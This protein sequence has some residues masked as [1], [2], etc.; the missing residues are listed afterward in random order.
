[1]EHYKILCTGN[2]DDFT[3]AHFVKEAFP[4]TVFVSRSNGYNLDVTDNKNEQ[5]FRNKIK[6]F[7][8]FINSSWIDGNQIN[9]LEI[10]QQEWLNKKDCYVIN[11][12]SNAEFDGDNF[13]DKN[14]SRKKLELRELSLASNTKDFRTTHIILGGLQSTTET[15]D[16]NKIKLNDVVETVKWILNCNVRIPLI[17]IEA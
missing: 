4:D 9:L 8:V 15:V 5:L 13:F 6:D 10:V 2:P 7:N 16:D 12:G 11:I 14:Y 3:I 17:S 1:M